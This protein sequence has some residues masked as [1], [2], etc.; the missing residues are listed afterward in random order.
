M[1][2]ALTAA[3]GMVTAPHHLA[4]QAGAGVLRDGGNA[5]EAMVAAAATIAVV[6]PHMN[7]IGGDGF[8]LISRPGK[9]AV[10][11]DACGRAA[12][13]ATPDWY[14][15]QGHAAIPVART[16]GGEHGGRRG[17]R[18]DRSARRS[19]A[20]ACR[21]HACC[22]DAIWYAREGAPV[23]QSQVDYTAKIPGRARAAARLRRHVPA[24]RLPPP[25]RSLQRFPALAAT[26]ERLAQRGL[27]DFYRGDVA[28]ALA[29]ELARL[30][31]PLRLDD[32]AA[33]SRGARRRRWRSNCRQAPRTT[34]RRRRRA[35][36]R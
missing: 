11:I 31:S 32:L 9:P 12:A 19:P 30:G 10:G 6:Y 3:R 7:S 34:C 1:L 26:F 2:K 35:W 15:N 24:R 20:D 13:L 5:V 8:W 25:A 14:R 28:H 17:V 22:E 33:A 21:S 27:D 29:A 23:T 16:A 4:A 18:L 36:R